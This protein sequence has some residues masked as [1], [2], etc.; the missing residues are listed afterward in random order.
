M[1]NA[2]VTY[3]RFWLTHLQQYGDPAGVMKAAG[4]NTWNAQTACPS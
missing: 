3:V 1:P 2:K 4:L